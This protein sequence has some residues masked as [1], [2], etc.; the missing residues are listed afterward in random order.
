ME[1][2][3]ATEPRATGATEDQQMP[4]TAQRRK[5]PTFHLCFW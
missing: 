3:R 5:F 4:A 1:R 2:N